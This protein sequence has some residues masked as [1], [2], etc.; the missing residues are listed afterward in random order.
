[1]GKEVAKRDAGY[2]YLTPAMRLGAFLDAQGKNRKEISGACG[3][4]EA[5]VSGW[6]G[7][8]RYR[9]ERDRWVSGELAIFDQRVHLALVEWVEVIDLARERLLKL[10]VAEREPGTPNIGA[11]IEAL[12]IIA[13]HPAT[14]RLLG[15][16]D[17][18]G[19]AS[20]INQTVTLH[21][22]RDGDTETIEVVE[23]EVEEV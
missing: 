18:T 12:K 13:G 6:R 17:D 5:T 19:P 20:N 22:H 15:M 23:G 1:M 7:W 11:Q 3:V 8:S 10:L 2:K 4:N 9:E 21:V 16:R 14:K